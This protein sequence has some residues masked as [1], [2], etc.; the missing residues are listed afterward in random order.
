MD[1]GTNS[2]SIVSKEE[3][4]SDSDFFQNV[5]LIHL[6]INIQKHLSKKV[7]SKKLDKDGRTIKTYDALDIASI[8]V[9][10]RVLFIATDVQ[11]T[12]GKSQMNANCLL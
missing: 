12:T 11:T 1:K 2:S 3:P 4:I 6:R 5:F 10:G 9:L 8:V 7:C